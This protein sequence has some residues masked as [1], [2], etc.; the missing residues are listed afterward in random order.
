MSPGGHEHGQDWDD[1]PTWYCYSATD[2]AASYDYTQ[3]GHVQTAAQGTSG[4][5]TTPQDV[6]GCDVSFT[7]PLSGLGFDSCG[8]NN[9]G[10]CDDHD[11]CYKKN[12]C[13]ADS[14]KDHSGSPC[15]MCNRAVK[16]C[17]LGN[18]R[19]D[20]ICCKDGTCGQPWY[21]GP[22]KLCTSVNTNNCIYLN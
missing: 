4:L 3:C 22:G 12:G 5:H 19:G 7:D 1:D 14:W 21:D 18:Y 9:G 8:W 13:T 10:C 11:A 15:D 16:D 20:S 2:E 17:V 6:Q